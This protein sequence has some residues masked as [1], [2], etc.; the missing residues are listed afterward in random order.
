MIPMELDWDGT[1]FTMKMIEEP[2]QLNFE[3]RMTL[4]D[5]ALA[6]ESPESLKD[7]LESYSPSVEI[8]DICFQIAHWDENQKYQRR[9]V[10]AANRF[11]LKDGGD[12]VIPAVRHYSKDM[13]AVIKQVE[14]KLVTRFVVEPD[15]GFIDQYSNYWTR[16]EALI[17]A[18]HAGQINT[19][20]EKG[21]PLDKLFSEDLY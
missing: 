13:S 14:D 21:W 6:K 2:K 11:K 17:I 10:C 20:R 3:D 18:T 4:L 12:L 5:N 15:Q 19:V 1:G 7:K 16:E 8:P 9:I